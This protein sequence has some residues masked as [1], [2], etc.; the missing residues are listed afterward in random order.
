MNAMPL[1]SVIVPAWN[2]QATL[3]ETLAAVSAQ[4]WPKLE[5]LIVDDGS[6]DATARIAAAY[7]RGEPRARLIRKANGGVAS[8]RN[9]GLEEAAGEWVAPIDSDDLWHPGKIE[10]QVRAALA[11]PERP[12]F[13]YCWFHYV[14]PTGL[15]VGSGARWHAEGRA[16]RQLAFHNFVGNGSAPLLW[17]E[18]ALSA[19]GYDKGLREA[20]GQGCE[21]LLL[22][23]EIAR[24]WPVAVVPEHLVGYRVQG[25]TMSRDD[26]Q[27]ARSWELVFERMRS[28]QAPVPAK[29]YRWTLG[30]R[31]F[32][33]AE[34]R[35]IA[36]DWRGMV[37]MLA[38]AFR[39]DPIRCGLHAA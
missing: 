6:T 13:V 28:C 10:K 31:S 32:E 3:A 25:G 38:R 36:R 22:Q 19:G 12:G 37:A 18:A 33:F 20:R 16:L 23:L 34:M 1:V 7:C 14:D 39:L 35:A 2:A 15:V 11:A 8:A 30:M 29:V 24:H 21:D 27:M 4:S 26:G 9:R 5:I 17:R